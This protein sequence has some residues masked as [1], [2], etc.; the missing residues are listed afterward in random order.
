VARRAP[1]PATD[2]DA[3]AAPVE[4]APRL[5]PQL[6]PQAAPRPVAPQVADDGYI[7]PADGT[8]TARYPAPR[9]YRRQYDAQA[10]QQY[11]QP[12]YNDGYAPQIYAPQ[13]Y[14]PRQYYQPRGYYTYQD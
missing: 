6:A 1:S 2:Y 10:Q 4:I 11:A 3:A 7:Y 8:D 13:V 12:Q 14:Q 9:G 5:A